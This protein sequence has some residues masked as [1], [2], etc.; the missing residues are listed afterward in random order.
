MCL[1]VDGWENLILRRL[2]TRRL[3][4]CDKGNNYF[5][6]FE[7]ETTTK[8]G[9]FSVFIRVDFSDFWFYFVLNHPLEILSIHTITYKRVREG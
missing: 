9:M 4:T 6:I 1:L 5:R 2:Y 7:T 3:H 8:H